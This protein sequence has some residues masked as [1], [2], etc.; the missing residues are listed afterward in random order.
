MKDVKIVL[1][2]FA[3]LTVQFCN[4]LSLW[5]GL[6]TVRFLVQHRRK[7][8]KMSRSSALIVKSSYYK[9]SFVDIF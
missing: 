6:C 8:L 4:H 9:N 1:K 7:G 2:S 3:V 5:S